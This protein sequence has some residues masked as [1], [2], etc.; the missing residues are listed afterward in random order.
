[1][2]RGGCLPGW[3][4][5]VVL[6]GELDRELK[7]FKNSECS[8]SA[9]S[10]LPASLPF[11]QST[12]DTTH[13]AT[14]TA[15]T[16]PTARLSLPLRLICGTYSGAVYG[17]ESQQT[18]QALLQRQ[19]HAPTHNDSQS[20]KSE[21]A[22]DEDDERQSQDDT[23]N[24]DATSDQQSSVSVSSA[25]LKSSLR[26]L[27]TSDSHRASVRSVACSSSGCWLASASTDETI[28][29]YNLLKRETFGSLHRHYG[30]VEQVVFY[31]A[32]DAQTQQQHPFMLSCGADGTVCIY[33][34]SPFDCVGRLRADSSVQPISS[35]AVHPSG[36]VLLTAERGHVIRM[37]SLAS[38][39]QVS[40]FHFK[41]QA[42]R[43]LESVTAL[44][45]SP[46]ATTYTVLCGGVA[47][48]F[49]VASGS[50]RNVVRAPA[51]PA[52]LQGVRR[53]ASIAYANEDLLL[54]GTESGELCVRS[55]VQ[56]ETQTQQITPFD[57]IDHTCELVLSLF[58]NTRVKSLCLA[59][60]QILIAASSE[61]DLIAYSLEELIQSATSLFAHASSAE[62]SEYEVNLPEP[63]LEHA[64][65]ARLTSMTVCCQPIASE[66]EVTRIQPLPET[67][68]ASAPASAGAKPTRNAKR[69][70][71]AT[72]A[73]LAKAAAAAE[74]AKP[75]KKR[76]LLI[77]H[78]GR[79]VKTTP[80]A[81]ALLKK[82]KPKRIKP[83]KSAAD[84]D[85][86]V[87]KFDRTGRSS[88]RGGSSRGRGGSS[89][90]GSSSRGRGG[91]SAPTR[92]RSSSTSRGGGQSSSHKKQRSH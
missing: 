20:L 4:A 61:G 23:L 25:A 38:M 56:I 28:Q 37:W 45:W 80:E 19:I 69:K 92:G 14:P 73:K 16:N 46:D 31:K 30:A 13:S 18:C 43:A 82:S 87:D 86:K 57:A 70:I 11:A 79:L 85:M 75:E 76:T 90:G 42:V 2:T 41:H 66:C 65:D 8:K 33:T 68:A 51:T 59:E 21:Q 26:L 64:L 50:V 17:L 78:N 60:Q 72:N 10:K 34:V 29:I 77:E 5:G 35:L 67:K 48:V 53:V 1:M 91:S 47:L 84:K 81:A 55:I 58:E 49:D 9:R 3:V 40:A 32:T 22:S 36:A 62:T 88:S 39:R 12:L 54:I 71:A 52:A 83:E 7:K 24:N 63:L 44:L 89:R 27:F 6:V 74:P 15:M